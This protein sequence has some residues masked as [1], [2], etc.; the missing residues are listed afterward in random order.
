MHIINKAM[1][2]FSFLFTTLLLVNTIL[3]AQAPTDWV[4]GTQYNSGVLVE[5]NNNFY[6]AIQDIPGSVGGTPD[7][8]TD[9]L[10]LIHI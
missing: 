9:Y 6:K 10:S 1:K 2:L 3:I 7:T 4:V 8:L 5:Y